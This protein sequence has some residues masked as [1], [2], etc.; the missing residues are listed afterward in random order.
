MYRFSHLVPRSTEYDNR[1]CSCG[2]KSGRGRTSFGLKAKVR[3]DDW[4]HIA[5]Q[6]EQQ[7]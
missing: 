2:A 4:I 7:S 3:H 5:K 1:E 6:P